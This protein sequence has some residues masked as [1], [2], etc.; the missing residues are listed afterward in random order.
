MSFAGSIFT[1]TPDGVFG[2]RPTERL[3]V[4]ESV[5]LFQILPAPQITVYAEGCPGSDAVE[6]G[7]RDPA[8]RRFFV[9]YK[10][11]GRGVSLVVFCE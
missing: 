3:T 7:P 5:A 8:Q 9:L 1:S 11:R 10:H 4:S 6:L 2:W